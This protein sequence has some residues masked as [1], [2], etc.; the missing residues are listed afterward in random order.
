VSRTVL[1][2]WIKIRT[3][4][5]HKLLVLIGVAFPLIVIT[6]AATFGGV[7]SGPDSAEMAEFVFGMSLVTAM[8][9]GVVTV[10]GLTSEYTHNT[11]RPTYA[12]TPNRPRVLL[13]KLIV[14]TLMALVVSTVTVVAAWT[15]GSTI[16]NSRGGDTSL[17]DDTVL[18]VLFC[19]VVLAVLVTWFGFGVG[20]IVRNSPASVSLVLLWPL[21]IEGLLQLVFALLDWDGASKWV[22]YQ[23]AINASASSPPEDALGRPGGQIVFACVG[24][25]LI[26]VGVWLDGRRDA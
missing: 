13:A 2:E 17:G 24:L 18:T 16:F 25:G 26:C 21:L 9:V 19:T 8:L 1:S 14:S 6:L 4:F 7:A 10:I 12:A 3:I 20:L 22:P 15:S 23:A 11:I 5:S